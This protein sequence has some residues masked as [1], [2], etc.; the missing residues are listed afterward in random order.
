VQALDHTSADP[1]AAIGMP[2]RRT[3]DD[4]RHIDKVVPAELDVH[5]VIDNASTHKTPAT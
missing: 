1:A 5:L 3:H 4:I 2:E